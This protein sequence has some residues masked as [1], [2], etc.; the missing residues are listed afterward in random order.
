MANAQCKSYTIPMIYGWIVNCEPTPD[1]MA[2]VDGRNITGGEP[3]I[4]LT[5]ASVILLFMQFIL[6][7]FL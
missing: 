3:F 6:V 5:H 4:S 2:N 1:I 7:E